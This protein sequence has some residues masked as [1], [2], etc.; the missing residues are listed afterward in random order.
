M[1]QV[2][3]HN[4]TFNVDILKLKGRLQEITQEIVATKTIVRR[5]HIDIKVSSEALSLL[6]G[7]LKPKATALCSL[8][9]L[10]RGRQHTPK[11]TEDQLAHILEHNMKWQNW[12]FLTKE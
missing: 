2:K 3:I 1:K 11:L 12:S 4:T 8:V 7:S 5:P 9:A 10:L 6:H